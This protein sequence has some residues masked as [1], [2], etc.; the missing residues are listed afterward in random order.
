MR[1]VLL[2]VMTLAFVAEVRGEP[3][4]DVVPSR[5]ELRGPFER[6]QLLVSQA[7]RADR[8]TDRTHAARF[9]SKNPQVVVVDPQGRVQPTG[10][11]ATE[12]E[13]HLDGSLRLIPVTV[14]HFAE[15]KLEFVRDVRPILNKMG[16][17]SAAC[18]AS[19]Y[20]KGGLKLSVLGFDPP[21]DYEQLARH[22]R[23]R[24]I[25][26]ARPSA[27]LL[28]R[29][30][31]MTMA[32]GGG[33]RFEWDSASAQTLLAWIRQGAPGPVKEPAEVLRLETHP[34]QRTGRPQQT[35]Q[36]RVVAHY[37]DGSSRDVTA[38]AKYDS[39]DEG[40]VQVD[41]LGHVELVGRGQTAAM[42]RYEQQTAVATF[43][44]PYA[45]GVALTGWDS[46]NIIDELAA[47]KF[48]ELGIQPSELC[49]DATFL[50]RAYLDAV[51]TLPTIDE[52]RA[53][54]Q[55]TDPQKRED[56]VDRLL[57]LTGDP[58][59][60]IYNDKYA[61]F[62][63]LRWSDLIRNNSKDLGEQGMWALHNWIRESF[64]VNKPLNTF[65]QELVTATGSIY[66]NGPANY[67][68]VNRDAPS[69][70]ESTA[71]L[72]LG[73]RLEC[74]KCHHHPFEAYSQADYYGLAAFFSRVGTKTSEEF[75][76]FGRETIV[77][78]RTSGDIRHP[79]TRQLMKPTP[80]GG[81]PVETLADRRLPLAEWLTANRQ[82]ARSIANRYMAYLLG[83]GL[84]DPVD[85]MRSTNPPSN[86]QLLEALADYFV[87]QDYDAKQLMRLIMTSRLYQ[88]SSVPTVENAADRRFYS[89]YYVKRLA[90][91]PL[92]DAVDDVTQVRTKFK[93][94]P[95]GTRAIEL[96]DAEY[97]NYFLNTFAK[98]KRASV[99]ECER[100]PHESLTQALHTLNGEIVS[101]KIADKKGRIA[102]L[103][104]AKADEV[105]IIDELFLAALAR[106]PSQAEQSWSLQK[107]KEVE[108]PQ[109]G[110][111]DI[112]WA[113]LNS[114][115]FLFVH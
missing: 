26:F 7:D 85:D 3:A 33:R 97:P 62:W 69:L 57:G 71:Q 28:L 91:E 110:F 49:D 27:S 112:L 56:L 53:F 63:T 41:R 93:S 25:N 51:G 73:V 54:L 107:L 17:A 101:S 37:H 40:V 45:E 88:L 52:T 47:A 55:S 18:H 109:E 46:R 83:R 38:M 84:V 66:S 13:V 8:G 2:C 1:S 42:I 39:L 82:F 90:A 80:L 74:A 19:Q 99:C 22:S 50:R 89:H 86:A 5:V 11:G 61:A 114:K 64:R 70:T 31:T 29:K 103:L 105:T 30:P 15:T 98:P 48:R 23:Q 106:P 44:V 75:G 113:L 102:R 104:Q 21:A 78:E 24:R 6:A 10:D 65:V 77:M 60:D 108:S 43:M 94:L 100:S 16:C 115:Q 58:E 12:I 4:I 59:L 68:R 92:L 20:G 96:P 32:H 87:E 81:E 76:L 9:I 35:Q 34:P 67:F 79:R 36:L 95:L 14:N 72:F 111:E